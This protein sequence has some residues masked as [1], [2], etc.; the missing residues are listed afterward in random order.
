M[1]R[2]RTFLDRSGIH[3]IGLFADEDIPRGSVVWEFDRR[4]DVEFSGPK[5]RAMRSTLAHESF[6]QLCR[7]AYKEGGA[8]Y[9]CMD[10]AQF[11]NHSS[12]EPNVRH[13]NGERNVMRAS[14][15]IW[16]GE[17][18]LCDYAEYSDPDDLHLLSMG[19]CSEKVII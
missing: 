7:Y 1:L 2:V 9:V 18:L 12:A 5:W 14:R 13:L 8:Y 3:G 19:L 17:E 6:E 15:D 16:R 4:V 10:N 11:M